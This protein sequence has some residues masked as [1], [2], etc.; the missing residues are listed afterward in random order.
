MRNRNA[1]PLSEMTPGDWIKI[2]VSDTGTGIPADVLPH[3]YDPFFT[4]KAPGQGN[5]LGLA[6]VYGIVGSHEGH[7]DV[8]SYVA[9]D[10]Q[11]AKGTTF[12]IYL[13]AL[14]TKTN[15]PSMEL[16]ATLATGSGETI[17]VVEDNAATR[18]ALVD[19]LQVLNY[20][21]LTAQN[22]EEAL[23]ILSQYED[24]VPASQTS[25]IDLIL[26]DVVMPIMGGVALL[27]ALQQQ[28]SSIG[29]V[30]L[31]GHPMEEELKN[32]QLREHDDATTPLVGWLLKPPS[33]EQLATAIAQG[34]R[35]TQAL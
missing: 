2:T 4:T 1:V 10:E 15:K 30:L 11:Q 25:P 23:A 7:I 33:L 21:V 3:I 26:S 22:G 28:K 19:S 8:K 17:L 29:V 27:Q 20:K 6:Q 34:L 5:G 12:T 32:I 31:T 13:P 9:E 35:Q 24:D 16:T 14:T 18:T